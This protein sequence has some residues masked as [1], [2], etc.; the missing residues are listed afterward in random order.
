M[1]IGT[2]REVYLNICHVK[3]VG[4][5]F[6]FLKILLNKLLYLGLLGSKNYETNKSKDFFQCSLIASC[7]HAWLF[8]PTQDNDLL[9]NCLGDGFSNY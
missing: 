4:L 8:M 3:R 6:G 7:W 2:L 1:G 9:R 5:L